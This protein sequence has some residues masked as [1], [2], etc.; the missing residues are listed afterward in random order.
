[1]WK[2][3]SKEEGHEMKRRI[4][5]MALGII[6]VASVG[7]NIYQYNQNNAMRL[8]GDHIQTEIDNANTNYITLNESASAKGKEIEALGNKISELEEKL[9][10]L[11]SANSDLSVQLYDLELM[12]TKTSS[13]AGKTSKHGWK[14]PNDYVEY[15]SRY[16]DM[17]S[18]AELF[19]DEGYIDEEDYR[20][21]IGD[22][23]RSVGSSVTTEVV[24]EPD[25]PTE[26][27]VLANLKKQLENGEITQE[28][29]D[30]CVKYVTENITFD[31]QGGFEI[32]PPSEPPVITSDTALEL[33]EPTN[34]SGRSFDFDGPRN[35]DFVG[36]YV[37]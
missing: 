29:Y 33:K 1:M 7:I 19:F 24:T 32:N 22:L 28:V 3:G 4:V 37:Q 6:A 20:R 8:R 12:K 13:Y 35:P 27:K 11:Q 34:G 23:E 36:V 15:G 31:G 16:E 9:S 10:G 17:R 21:W 25:G 30:E 26:D 18:D 5:N 14:Y 2:L